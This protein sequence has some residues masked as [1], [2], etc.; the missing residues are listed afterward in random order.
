MEDLTQDEASRRRL[1]VLGHL[2]LTGAFKLCEVDLAPL[3]PPEALAPFADELAQRERKRVQR[4]KQEARRAAREAAAA[5]AAEAAAA[6]A[7]PSEQELRAM[8]LPSASR[9]PE[10]WAAGPEAFEAEFASL[11][12]SPPAAAA[13]AAPPQQG[14]SFARMTRMGF[15]ATGPSLPG[16]GSPGGGA[17]N[18]PLPSSSAG[19]APGASPGA[20]EPAGPVLLGAW[21]PK[22]AV[23]APSAAGASGGA[24]AT[25]MGG[26]GRAFA[27]LGVGRP[28][29]V[30]QGESAS[31]SSSG[32]GK[33]K[34]KKG[35]KQVLLMSS[36]AQRRY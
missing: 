8:P 21:G 15:A 9:L 12:S 35:G 27:E 11:G 17:A 29:G 13:P 6:R 10:G 28:G 5:A 23:P 4:S 26:L 20:A 3:L 32:G 25:A 16:T 31:G 2:P 18:P 36:G 22:K 33:G 19:P 14:I 24:T 7:G 34:G 30:Q 1:R